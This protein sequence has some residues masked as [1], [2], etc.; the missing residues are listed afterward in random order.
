MSEGVRP[1][2]ENLTFEEIHQT[3]DDGD[4]QHN[5]AGY[6][7]SSDVAWPANPDMHS[8]AVRTKGLAFHVSP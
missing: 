7:T 5:H 3:H 4:D 1:V 8:H 6:S 2:V